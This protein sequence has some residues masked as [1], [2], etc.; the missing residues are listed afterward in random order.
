MLTL[1]VQRFLVSSLTFV[2]LTGMATL[3]GMFLALMSF[4]GALI[5]IIGPLILLGCMAIVAATNAELPL[6]IVAVALNRYR[7][8]VASIGIR[9]EH[10][11]FVIVLGAWIAKKLMQGRLPRLWS[12]DV[13]L[14]IYLTVAFLASLLNAPHP[15]ESIQFLVLMA[16]AV[17]IYWLVTR[18]IVDPSTFQRAMKI[19]VIVGVAEAI[20]GIIAWLLYSFGINLGVQVNPA[21]RTISPYGTLFEANI[22]GSFVMATSLMLAVLFLSPQFRSRRRL[23]GFA[24][25]I[26]LVAVALSLTR[27]AWVGFLVGMP[28]VLLFSPGKRFGVLIRI[29]A[30]GIVAITLLAGVGFVY[31]RVKAPSLPVLAEFSTRVSTL[32]PARLVSDETVSQRISVFQRAINDW[33]QHPWLGNGV[34]SFG[35]KYRTT[36]FT[37]DW[38]PNMV[39]MALHDTGIIGLSIL[40]AWL[41]RL[42]LN[43]MRAI[44]HAPPSLT[45]TALIALASG[46]I[47]LLVAYQTTTAFWLGFTWV[48]LGLIRAGTTVLQ[49]EHRMISSP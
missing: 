20:F 5:V 4:Y 17:A 35:Q 18:V 10:V 45:R 11:V 14:V 40:L 31:Q 33:Q 39:L 3:A 34:N 27:G 47:G 15:K 32:S 43:T 6:L 21:D 49:Y 2:A 7:F 23:I 19:L 46:F 44:Q 38:I 9:I 42:G 13:L 41:G 37:R 25:A 28:F 8:D 36:A 29:G 22:F 16:I 1:R 12:D 48:H 26:T 30:I 24:L